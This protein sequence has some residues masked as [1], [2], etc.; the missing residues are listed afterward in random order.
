MVAGGEG[1]VQWLRAQVLEPYYQY[2]NHEF[3]NHV[4]LGQSLTSSCFSFFIPKMEL[5]KWACA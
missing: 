1:V 3:S 5:I 2:L 4:T